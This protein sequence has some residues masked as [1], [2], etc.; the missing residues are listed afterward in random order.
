MSP[1][2]SKA[3][4]EAEPCAFDAG[5]ISAPVITGMGAVTPFG[6]G[7]EALMEG[8][9]SNRHGFRGLSVI[10][11]A[12]QRTALA[13]E[14]PLDEAAL[15]GGV[16]ES[17]T[18]LQRK[19]LART[20]G[21][22]LAAT[23]EALQQAGLDREALSDIGARVGLFFGSSTGAMREGE[24]FFFD[25]KDRPEK[26]LAASR[27]ATQQNS[28]PGDC[29]ARHYGVGGPHMT[30]AT[31]CCA[32]TMAIEAAWLA[33]ATDE[34]DMALVGGADGLCNL[35][36]AGFNSLRAV[37]ANPCQPFRKERDGLCIGEGAGVLVLERASHAMERGATS[38]AKLLAV[39]S[40]CDAHHMTAPHPEGEGVVRAIERALHLAQVTVRDV[41]FINAHGTG[42]PHNDAAEAAAFRRVFGDLLG[43]LP[44]TS[45]KGAIG[46]LLGS[47][48]AVEAVVSVR[49]LMDAQLHPTPG[50]FR[51][52][53]ELGLDLVE[54]VARELASPQIGLSTNLA[55]GG[56][57]AVAVLARADFERQEMAKR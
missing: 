21:F 38:L 47:A 17:M 16:F 31:A 19:R 29:V 43:H 5:S 13:G 40:S 15:L 35:T 46:H 4:S 7:V 12:E 6:W 25:L 36:F 51:A 42:T 32:S 26:R 55:F 1:R 10:D 14:V 28:G 57:N 33:I 18:A 20:D 37:S 24:D 39:A 48:G 50:S 45:T 3:K 49:S 8:A 52:D 2:D 53:P 56:A 44:V 34:I 27:L 54:S 41:S 30:F 22:A 11:A 23:H 9:Y